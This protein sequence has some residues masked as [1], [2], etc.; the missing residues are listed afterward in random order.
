MNRTDRLL[1]IVLELQA[2]GWQRAEDLAHR[3]EISKRT[4][5][6]DMQALMESGVPVLSEPGRGFTI[7]DG[8][9]LPPLHFT[10]DEAILLLLGGDVME[11]TF[12]ERYR[13]NA[14][15]AMS[16]IKAA[17]PSHVQ[18][19]VDTLQARFRFVSNLT[20]SDTDNTVL[21]AL[22]RAII[23]TR[24]VS[25]TYFSRPSPH[26]TPQK[27]NRSADPYA[28]VHVN[29]AWHMVGYCHLRQDLRHFRVDRIENPRVTLQNFERPPDFMPDD[30]TRDDHTVTVCLLFD[31]SVKR[32]VQEQPSYF[33]VDATDHP[34]GWLVTLRVRDED[35]II[36]WILGWGAR[37]RVLEPAS[38]IARIRI[39]AEAILRQ[40]THTTV[41]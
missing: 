41:P 24:R 16:K 5:Y 28:L 7:M 38:L 13:F 3:F 30:N 12:D 9:F 20:E 11:Q 29:G 18:K 35:E 15:T 8:Y 32:W 39:E 14:E 27:S 6:R 25:F 36:Q 31:A 33:Q 19:R 23:D 4:I 22:R 21:S 10:E 40:H 2:R 1:S 37:V 17:L 26:A 34:D